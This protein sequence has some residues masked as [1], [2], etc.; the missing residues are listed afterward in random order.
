[1]RISDW[2]S[3]VCSSDLV[4]IAAT[5]HARQHIEDNDRPGV[6]DM[7]VAVDR[8][9]ADVHRHLLGIKRDEFFLVAGKRV[10]KLHGSGWQKT[11]AGYSES[12]PMGRRDHASVSASLL[13]ASDRRANRRRHPT[14]SETR[15]EG[16]EG[17]RK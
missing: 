1:M 3:D 6:A 12:P 13:R 16:K 15:R 9:P 7:R 4:R 10:V 17:V 2:S 8:R 5:Q 14:R 11:R